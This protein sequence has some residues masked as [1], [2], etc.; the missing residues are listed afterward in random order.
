MRP[1]DIIND[2]LFFSCDYTRWVLKEAMEA[3]R[4]LVRTE[5]INSFEDASR[6]LNKV[7]NGSLTWGLQWNL[8]GI[9]LFQ[10]WKQ[11][12]QHRM[13][14]KADTKQVL[15]RRSIMTAEIG[16]DEGKYKRKCKNGKEQLALF[17]WDALLM[18]LDPTN[19]R[20]I[21]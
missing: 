10:I 8:F 9:V 1:R 3:S 21:R 7:T 18:G 14:V 20:A 2:H 6:E 19:R 17:Q 11:R 5:V 12:N 15:L 13:Q 4:S 16:F